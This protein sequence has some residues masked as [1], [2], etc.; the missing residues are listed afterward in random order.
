[1]CR[2]FAIVRVQMFRLE[3]CDDHAGLPSLCGR[4]GFLAAD[5]EDLR[6][7]VLATVLPVL[8]C[9]YFQFC[10]RFKPEKSTRTGNLRG[11]LLVL[12]QPSTCLR[13]S[14]GSSEATKLRFLEAMHDCGV[15]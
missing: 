11:R 2:K 12:D 15:L 7:L 5:A 10:K 3:P 14:S 1:M 4:P 6:A 13:K 9:T 8:G